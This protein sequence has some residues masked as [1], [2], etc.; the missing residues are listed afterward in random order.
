MTDKILIVIYDLWSCEKIVSH[1]WTADESPQ[2]IIFIKLRH[3]QALP[4]LPFSLSHAHTFTPLTHWVFDKPG[5]GEVEMLSRQTMQIRPY[6]QGDTVNGYNHQQNLQRGVY[7]CVWERVCAY[8]GISNTNMPPASCK[9]IRKLLQKKRKERE[10]KA[11]HWKNLRQCP[12]RPSTPPLTKPL[13]VGSGKRFSHIQI[14]T[15]AMRTNMAA[16]Q[17]WRS[18]FFSRKS[19]VQL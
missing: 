19:Q 18:K 8:A 4:P 6:P 11:R 2:E 9:Q 7:V 16:R 1:G 3:Q 14:L 10:K 13:S 5:N 12:F 15:L 17:G